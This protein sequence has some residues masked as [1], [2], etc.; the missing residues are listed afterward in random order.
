MTSPVYVL[1][2]TSIVIVI[3]AKVVKTF[4]INRVQTAIAK[5]MF[6]KCTHLVMFCPRFDDVLCDIKFKTIL[7]E[8]FGKVEQ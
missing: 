7:T 5:K 8:Q 6:Q 1:Y 4:C 3:V 2:K